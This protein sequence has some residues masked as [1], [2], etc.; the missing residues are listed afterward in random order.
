MV[1]R[2]YRDQRRVDTM[3][4]VRAAAL[5]GGRAAGTWMATLSDGDGGTLGALVTRCA[6]GAGPGGDGGV[7][8]II[9]RGVEVWRYGRKIIGLR[10]GED[11]TGLV[12]DAW[13]ER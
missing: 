7:R 1:A 12:V 13:G 6:P 5:A 10:A 11:V 2:A 3:T 9:V 4:R 8:W